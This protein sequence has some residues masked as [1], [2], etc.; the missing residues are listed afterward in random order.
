MSSKSGHSASGFSFGTFVAWLW[1]SYVIP[2]YHDFHKCQ[3]GQWP[4]EGAWVFT[5][6]AQVSSPA[7]LQLAKQ[8]DAPSSLQANWEQELIFRPTNCPYLSLSCDHRETLVP[9]LGSW[10]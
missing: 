2:T 6:A 8:G 9:Y 7:P 10:L 5:P 3:T 1:E 4:W